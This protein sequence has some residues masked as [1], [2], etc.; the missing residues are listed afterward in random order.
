MI[1]DF[2][3]I[4]NRD[5]RR[6]FTEISAFEK[7]ENLWKTTGEITNS[8]GNLTL[9]LIGNLNYYVGSKI[10]DTGYERDR[11]AE[12]SMQNVP[13]D[14]ILMQIEETQ[15]MVSSVLKNLDDSRL[16][17]EFPEALF[18]HLMTLGFFLIHLSG[19]LMY[20]L[21]QINYLRRM[22]ETDS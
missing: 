16:N 4:L 20:H 21:G 18:G 22:L 7:E 15:D 13:R 14:Q 8:A 6:L 3:K 10:G 19:H 17:E 11:P 5:L 2:E 12:F 9:H 1:N